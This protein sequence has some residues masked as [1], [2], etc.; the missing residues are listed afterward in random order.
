[1]DVIAHLPTNPKP[2]EP[3]QMGERALDHPPLSPQTGTVRGA[4][5][6]DQRLHAEIPD[7]AA[8]LVVVVAAVTEHDVRTAPGPAAL[9]THGRYGLEQW[10]ELG[11]VVAVPAGQG[12]GKRDAGGIGDQMMLAARPAPVDRASSRLGP[13]LKPGC[14]SR[15]RLPGRSPGR[16]RRGVR[17]AGPRAAEATPRPR[18]TRPG[19]ASTS[20]PSRSRVPAAGV[21]RRSRCAA[22]TGCPG[23]PVGPDAACVPGAEF[24]AQPWATAVRPSPTTRHQLPTASA[25]PPHT[26]GSTAPE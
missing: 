24:G 18:S 6:G 2:A 15:R 13:P 5:A 4:A 9:A 1:M 3:V 10:N 12:G 8:V 16:S 17:R 7:Q 26:P 23:T 22:Q 21:P 14:G 11:D 19:G 20:C 25:E